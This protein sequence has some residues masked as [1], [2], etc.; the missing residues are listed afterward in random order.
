M[1]SIKKNYIFNV[2]NQILTVLA[3]L[4]TTPYISR[5]LRV[6]GIGEYSYAYSIVSY[7]VLFAGLGTAYYGQ[8]E[9]SYVQDNREK[10][11]KVFWEIEMVSLLSSLSMF[12]LYLGFV[13]F[14]GL[15]KIY[16]VLSINIVAIIFDISWLF[17]GMED[18]ELI[19]KRNT[20]FK[21]FNIIYIFAFVKTE[22]DLIIYALGCSSMGLLGNLSLWLYLSRF[23]NAFHMY[24]FSIWERG[25]ETFSLFIP[26]VAISIYTV[27]DKT[28]LGYFAEE[29]IENGYYEQ[30]LKI[31]KLTLTLVTSLVAV[32]IPRVG[33]YFNKNDSER[34]KYYIYKSYNFIWLL[35]IPLCIGLSCI[36][37]NLV[38]WFFG[39]E[40][41]KVKI[42]LPLLSLLIVF[43]GLSNV[44]GLGYLV[45]T[46]RQKLLAQSVLTGAICNYVL[47][48]ILIPRFL[49][50]GAAL[51]SVCAELL[52]TTIQF[53][54]VRKEFPVKDIFK[55]SKN[56]FVAGFV[57]MIVLLLENHFL[58]AGILETIAM[59]VTGSIVY[60]L[61]LL[62]LKDIFFVQYFKTILDK[63]FKRG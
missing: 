29:K 59:I 48:L 61:V 51:A 33:L 26:N 23:V 58:Q 20:V 47:N 16:M 43:I 49:S 22:N 17:Q 1:K 3:P 57:M 24:R 13:A 34:V 21:I 40:Y 63:C 11:S 2:C 6:Q 18:F 60:F 28:M 42:L 14:N 38:P 44:T 9:I 62:V 41:N 30:S 5:V 52:V 27:L 54:Y 53:Y 46:K 45:P 36:S 12:G 7:F 31:S 37:N 35:S 10:R 8:R 4:I 50:L 15:S 39:A 32:V 56:Y 55:L 19:V 25:K